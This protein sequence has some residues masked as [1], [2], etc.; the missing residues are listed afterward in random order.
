MFSV[1]IP[2]KGRVENCKRAIQSIRSTALDPV[3]IVVGVDGGER[4]LYA[5]LDADRVVVLEDNRGCSAGMHVL[6]GHATGDALMAGSDDFVWLT[7]GWDRIFMDM[8]KAD[9][10]I[11]PYWKESPG[12]HQ[13]ACLGSVSRQ[14]YEVA[15]FFPPHFRHFLADNWIS[16]IA[17]AVGKLVYV[18]EVVIDHM[19][20]KYNKAAYDATYYARGQPDWATWR[21]TQGER[22]EIIRKL[23]VAICSAS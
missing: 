16:D 9:P 2:T 17:K 1:L 11:V 4:G 19:S 10:F 6:Q 15:G 18:P 21:K 12:E 23:R 8:F 7:P 22:D 13:G 20:F 3:E 5:G 14:W